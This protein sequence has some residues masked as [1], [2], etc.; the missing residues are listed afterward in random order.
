MIPL[1]VAVLSLS[2]GCAYL[3]K[4]NTTT[5]STGAVVQSN[6]GY[7][8]PVVVTAT[9]VVLDLSKSP[10]DKVAKA[11]IISGVAGILYEYT[12]GTAP[13]VEALNANLNNAIPPS[14]THW[15]TFIDSIGS[16]YAVEY[17]KVGGDNKVALQVIAAIAKALQDATAPIIAAG[18]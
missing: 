6:L 3:Q 15:S 11:K 9:T 2:T 1:V 5:S 18:S 7:I 10:A 13:T 4:L 12:N 14:V 16:L 17:N 8:E